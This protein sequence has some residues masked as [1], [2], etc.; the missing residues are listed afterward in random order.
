[1]QETPF[2]Q[3]MF[4]PG[5]GGQFPQDGIPRGPS[6]V[7]LRIHPHPA[8]LPHGDPRVVVGRGHQAG[9]DQ[10]SVVQAGE[11]RS[12]LRAHLR[13]GEGLGVLVRQVQAHPLPRRGMRPLRRRSDPGQGAPRAHGPCGAG[14][15]GEPHLVLQGRA[16]PHRAPARHVGARAGARALLR[17]LRGDR[18]RQ[19]R[20]E[21]AGDPRRGRV[22]RTHL[23]LQEQ[24]PGQDGRGGHSRP[25][26]RARPGRAGLR[27]AHHREDGDQRAAQEGDPEAPA[28]RRGLPPER[29]RAGVDDPRGG[30][31]AASGPAPAGSA[32]GRPLRHQRSQRS[33]PSRHQSQQPAQE[34]DGDPRA[35]GHPAQRE[36]HAP[37]SGGRALR[38][39]PPLACGA[40]SG[41][42]AA[43]VALRHA[44]GQAGAVPPEPARQ[45][46]GLLGPLRDRGRSRTQA[47][48]VRAPQDDGAGAVQAVHHQEPRGRGLRL[49]REERQASGG[50]G[51]PAGLGDPGRDHQGSPG[52]LEPRPHAAPSWASRRSSRCWWKAR[53]SVSIRWCAPPSTPT[54]TATRWPCTCRSDSRPRSRAPSSCSRATTS[55]LRRTGG[56]WPPR[57]RTSCSASPTSPA[58]AGSPRAARSRGASV[59]ARKCAGPTT[60]AT[61]CCTNRSSCGWRARCSPPPPVA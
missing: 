46:R 39:R 1:M 37:G 13:S 59:T 48:P 22:R 54:S 35:G 29:Q 11:G 61:C 55:S 14:G 16:Q 51:D 26:G 56:R 44:Q 52:A 27:A 19:H 12:L 9:D 2:G 49:H 32:G 5:K 38:Q 20:P 4:G 30:P 36:A 10:L 42:P 33:L 15:A 18:S 17:V 34:A 43:E 7:Q 41:E 47:A 45:A 21:A 6:P 8:R 3:S 40:R 60:T 50:A 23:R 53:P 31:G 24:V 57:A 25:P 58:W 28:R